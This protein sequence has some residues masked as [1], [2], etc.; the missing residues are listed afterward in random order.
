MSQWGRGIFSQTV[1]LAFDILHANDGLFSSQNKPLT[2]D[3]ILYL[4]VVRSR[5][6]YNFVIS[7]FLKIMLVFLLIYTNNWEVSLEILYHFDRLPYFALA[8]TAFFDEFPDPAFA[9][10]GRLQGVQLCGLFFCHE[11][12]RA[13]ARSTVLR[14]AGETPYVV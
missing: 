8:T 11:F 7:V 3:F 4:E 9:L 5:L 1:T 2:T 10:F 6:L 14:D 13:C 12:C